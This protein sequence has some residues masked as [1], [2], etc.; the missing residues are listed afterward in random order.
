MDHF[1]S[2]TWKELGEP[3]KSFSDFEHT[4]TIHNFA[5]ATQRLY[6]GMPPFYEDLREKHKKRAA[7]AERSRATKK[8]LSA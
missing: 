3:H 6:L 2:A 8:A 5:E 7:K 4:R 1:L